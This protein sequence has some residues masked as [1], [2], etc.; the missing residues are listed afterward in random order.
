M[1]KVDGIILVLSC[2]KH[3]H[4]RLEKYKLPKDNYENW[5]QEFESRQFENR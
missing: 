5:K 3:L 4:T 2:Q 1:I